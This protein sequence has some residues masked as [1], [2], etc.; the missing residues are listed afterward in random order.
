[1][2]T[3][4]AHGAGCWVN[5]DNFTVRVGQFN[6]AVNIHVQ[7]PA[8]DLGEWSSFVVPCTLKAHLDGGSSHSEIGY[9]IRDKMKTALDSSG[10]SWRFAGIASTLAVKLCREF[11]KTEGWI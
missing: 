4:W 7:G 10:V 9:I 2:K 6:G 11:L 1:M 8:H 3:N 5:H